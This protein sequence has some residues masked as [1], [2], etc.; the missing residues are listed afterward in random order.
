[1]NDEPGLR[2]GQPIG[3]AL[4]A[5]GKELLGGVSLDPQQSDAS[6]IHD[7][8]R[9]MKRWRAFLRLLEPVLGEAA[10]RLRTEARDLA[11]SLAGARDAQAALDALGDLGEDY[12][13]LPARSVATVSRR[14]GDIRAAAEAMTLGTT[15][16]QGLREALA[17]TADEIELW[18]IQNFDFHAIAKGLTEGYRRARRARPADW[19][20]AGAEDLHHLRQRVVT[21]RY[22][23]ELVEAPWPRLS[24]VWV[25]EAQRLRERLGKHQDLAVLAGLIA[26]KAPLARWRGKLAPAIESRQRDHIEAAMRHAGRLFAEKP[27]A[28]QRRIE[29]MWEAES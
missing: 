29:A 13:A 7:F 14:I 2:P 3:P 21:H 5:I 10:I 27:Q 15:A 16:R 19:S 6:A 12:N 22:Q 26:P 23:M 17:R 1:M 8:R 4:V 18:P 28:F 25:G 24:R 9:R 20:A 11:R